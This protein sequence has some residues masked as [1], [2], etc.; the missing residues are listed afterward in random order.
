MKKIIVTHEELESGGLQIHIPGVVGNPADMESIPIF[1]EK[2]EG[3]IR[4]IIWNGKEDPSI[5]VLEMER[6]TIGDWKY[7]VSNDDTRLGYDEWVEHKRE[8]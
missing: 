8:E 2:Y 6:L 3:D 5:I 7:E 4:V 1:I